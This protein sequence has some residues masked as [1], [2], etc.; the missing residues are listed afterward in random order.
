[1]EVQYLLE[2]AENDSQSDLALE[3]KKKPNLCFCIV[4]YW[5]YPPPPITAIQASKNYSNETGEKGN[6]A[7]GILTNQTNATSDEESQVHTASLF[8]GSQAM[9]T[10]V[11][12]DN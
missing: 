10:T 2:Y 5:I 1:M 8:K 12:N 7:V 11:L 6:I 4:K 3:K 9:G